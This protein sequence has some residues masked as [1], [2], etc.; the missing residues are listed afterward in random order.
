MVKVGGTWRNIDQIKAKDGGDW[1]DVS[2]AWVKEN[3]VWR[4][5]WSGVV[6]MAEYRARVNVWF[7]PNFDNKEIEHTAFCG[8]ESDI[9][10][11]TACLGSG[12]FNRGEKLSFD[13]KNKTYLTTGVGTN[14]R[15]NRVEFTAPADVWQNP[16]NYRFGTVVNGY[17]RGSSD[18]YRPRFTLE[19]WNGSS[20]VIFYQSYHNLASSDGCSDPQTDSRKHYGFRITGTGTQR[21]FRNVGWY[22]EYYNTPSA[23]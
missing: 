1:R 23:F 14:R 15:E 19:Y 11:S 17:A 16:S 7:S 8:I 4:K 21:S 20:W 18:A 9:T 5:A 13:Y 3:G 22:T 12:N 6:P 2:D 10:V